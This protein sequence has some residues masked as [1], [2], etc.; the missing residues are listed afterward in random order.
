MYCPNCGTAEQT[1][2]SYCRSCGIY[3]PKF[4]DSGKLPK[5]PAE[6]FRLSIVFNVLTA[7]ASFSMA[8]ALIVIHAGKDDVHPVIFSAIS[9]MFVIAIWQTI[10]LFNNL[11]L[12]N[13]FVRKEIETSASLTE[14]PAHEALPEADFSNVVQSSVT[15]NTTRKL[16]VER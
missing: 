6:Q 1:S 8:I 9:F 13:R 5:T 2:E 16:K 15:E 3:L 11:K 12:R 4:G 14:K 7:V 10:S